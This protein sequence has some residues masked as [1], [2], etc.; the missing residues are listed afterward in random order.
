MTTK[1]KTVKVAATPLDDV[2][3]THVSMVQHA[4]NRT[5]FKIVKTEA[6][7]NDAAMQKVADKVRKFFS[8]GKGPANVTAIYLH[9]SEAKLR[10][11]QLKD[12]GFRVDKDHAEFNGDVLVLKQEGYAADDEGS[13]VTLSDT[14]AVQV[15]TIAK[16]FCSW[17]ATTVFGETLQSMGFYPGVRVAQD[18][19]METIYQ[20]MYKANSPEEAA[21]DLKAATDAFGKHVVGLTKLMPQTVFKFEQMLAVEFE[22]STVQSTETP[23]IKSDEAMTQKTTVIKEA[24]PGDL[25]GLF[26]TPAAAAPAVA[27]KTETPAPEAAPAKTA[28]EVAAEEAAAA[29][30]AA[31]AATPPAAAA[32]EDDANDTDVQKLAKAFR[33]GLGTLMLEVQKTATEQATAMAALGDRLT[34]VETASTAAVVKAEQAIAK[35][36]NTVVI[37]S[38]AADTFLDGGSL[39]SSQGQTRVS[40]DD[41]SQ[42]DVLA[43]IFPELDAIASTRRG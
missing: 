35:A 33:A 11:P 39:V 23:I 7:P 21:T 24:V 18:A 22:P 27:A 9:K 20:I 41:N 10:M 26:D 43:G 2:N 25:D 5:P 17:N 4:A 15:D 6:I 42:N 31:A 14:I 3:V 32:D 29:E 37:A 19:L 30:A 36:E 40:K 28:D 12:L 34:A 16:D 1:T 8:E 38:G 13:V